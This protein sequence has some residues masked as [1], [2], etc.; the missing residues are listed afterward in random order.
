M[1]DGYILRQISHIDTRN[2]IRRHDRVRKCSREIII[3]TIYVVVDTDINIPDSLDVAYTLRD[4]IPGPVSSTTAA[5]STAG[6]DFT[7][8]SV[9]AATR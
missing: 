1:V 4:D 6:N 3:R 7:I 9:D 5:A 8:R 2:D